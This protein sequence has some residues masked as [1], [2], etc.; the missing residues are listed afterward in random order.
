MKNPES[1]SGDCGSMGIPAGQ[2]ELFILSEKTIML[3]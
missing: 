2:S 3:G 1:G